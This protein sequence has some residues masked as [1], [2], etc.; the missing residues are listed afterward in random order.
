MA[1]ERERLECS[2]GEF[3]ARML[4]HCQYSELVFRLHFCGLLT[5]HN[6]TGRCLAI[7][8]KE[9]LMFEVLADK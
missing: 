1:K 7:L 6:W 2:R 3:V 5:P 9:R 4:K 8:V